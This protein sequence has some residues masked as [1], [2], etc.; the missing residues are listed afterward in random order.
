MTSR[1]LEMQAQV[2]G[3]AGPE[4]GLVKAVP[5]VGAALTREEGK[6]EQREGCGSW[7]L[8]A[9]PLKG[10]EGRLGRRRGGAGEVGEAGDPGS[11]AHAAERGV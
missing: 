3:E 8:G 7:C 1:W 2:L 6:E 9:L 10:K 5:E 11:T 4:R